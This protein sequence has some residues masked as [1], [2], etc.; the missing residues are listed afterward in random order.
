MITIPMVVTTRQKTSSLSV[1]L[2]HPQLQERGY[3]LIFFEHVPPI[4]EGV[5][6]NN[7]HPRLLPQCHPKAARLAA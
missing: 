1:S 7:D 4:E 2:V 3:D 5:C 6:A